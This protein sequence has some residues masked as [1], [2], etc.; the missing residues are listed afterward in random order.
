MG[1]RN[2]AQ[3]RPQ[4]IVQATRGPEGSPIWRSTCTTKTCAKLEK[5]LAG[6]KAAVMASL[7]TEFGSVQ[8]PAD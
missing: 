3:Y 6:Q 4:R 8:L 7:K 2:G 1:A 5:P